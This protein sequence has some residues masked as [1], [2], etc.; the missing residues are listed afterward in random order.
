[1]I[2]LATSEAGLEVKMVQNSIR[3][4]PRSY[5]T[6]SVMIV[7]TDGIDTVKTRVAVIV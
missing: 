3:F 6:Y 5:G 1:L 7:A 4:I 2:F